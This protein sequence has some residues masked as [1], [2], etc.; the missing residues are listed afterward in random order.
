VCVCVCMCARALNLSQRCELFTTT[1]GSARHCEAERTCPPTHHTREQKQIKEVFLFVF[2]ERRVD[3]KA[4]RLTQIQPLRVQSSMRHGKAWRGVV[5][6]KRAYVSASN[7]EDLP[8]LGKL[9]CGRLL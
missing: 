3:E 1:A 2:V 6:R 4:L 8:N 5:L 9:S 7:L